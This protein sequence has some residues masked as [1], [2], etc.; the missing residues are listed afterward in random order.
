MNWP[1]ALSLM[2]I[3]A[4]SGTVVCVAFIASSAKKATHGDD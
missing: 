3:V 1:T 2:C 4:V